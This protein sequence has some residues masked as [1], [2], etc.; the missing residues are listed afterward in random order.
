MREI[1]HLVTERV[2]TEDRVSESKQV[3]NNRN[4]IE[5]VEIIEVEANEDEIHGRGEIL[6]RLVFIAARRK[7]R[8]LQFQLPL[9]RA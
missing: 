3:R 4:N 5:K 9:K 8:K 7:L 6:V 1:K 2:K